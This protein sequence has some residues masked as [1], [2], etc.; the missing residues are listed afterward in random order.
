MKRQICLWA[1]LCLGF[2]LTGCGTQI[3]IS[4]Q[5]REDYLRSIK[6]ALHYWEKPAMTAEGKRADWVACGGMLDGGYSSDAPAG[7]STAILLEANR[8]KREKIHA[9]MEM[10][11]YRFNRT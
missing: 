6:P 10:K 5:A 2:F 11:G 9:C 7:S 8:I 3:G 4:G 1:A